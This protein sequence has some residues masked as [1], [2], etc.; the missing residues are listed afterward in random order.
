VMG[1]RPT[2]QLTLQFVLRT[3]KRVQEMTR[4]DEKLLAETL[5][6]ERA[7]PDVQGLGEYLETV[8]HF[9][10]KLGF[11]SN[12]HPNGNCAQCGDEIYRD[13]NGA[14]YCSDRCKQRAYRLRLNGRGGNGETSQH[15]ASPVRARKTNVTKGLPFSLL[16]R[17]SGLPSTPSNETLV[18]ECGA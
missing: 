15:D 17:R 16:P 13:H 18:N 11:D 5:V 8:G 4:L 9:M 7:P 6:A 2:R 12:K 14:R 10:Q 3:L 1:R